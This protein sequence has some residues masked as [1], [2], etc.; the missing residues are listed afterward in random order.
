[1]NDE[2]DSISITITAGMQEGEILR[3]V[4]RSASSTIA[5]H[6]MPTDWCGRHAAAAPVEVSH[7]QV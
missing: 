2:D 3:V 5:H 6:L 1:M 4:Y 7:R